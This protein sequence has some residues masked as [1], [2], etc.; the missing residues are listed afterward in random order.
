M[1]KIKEQCGMTKMEAVH[2]TLRLFSLLVEK[3]VLQPI[4]PTTV[5]LI[6]DLQNKNHKVISNSRQIN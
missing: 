3:C 6:K 5:A 4:E 1:H 2:A